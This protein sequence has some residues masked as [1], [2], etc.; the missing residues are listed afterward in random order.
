MIVVT[1]R[2]VTISPVILKGAARSRGM[3]SLGPQRVSSVCLVSPS[4]RMKCEVNGKNQRDTSS[5][6]KDRGGACS[7]FQIIGALYEEN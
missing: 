1:T 5:E 7:S 4:V 3:P 6:T 2:L